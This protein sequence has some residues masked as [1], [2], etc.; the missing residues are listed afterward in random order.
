MHCPTYLGGHDAVGAHLLISVVNIVC[1]S[2]GN[3]GKNI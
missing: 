2:E 3:V 1:F